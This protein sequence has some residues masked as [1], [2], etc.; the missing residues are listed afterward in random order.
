MYLLH[1]KITAW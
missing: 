1:E